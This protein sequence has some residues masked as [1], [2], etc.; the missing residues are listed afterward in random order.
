[1]PQIDIDVTH[2]TESNR[3]EAH[4]NGYTA[5]LTYHMSGDT[6][7]FTHTG[8][9]PALEGQGVGSLLAKTGLEYAKKNNLKVRTLCWFVDGYI[10]RHVEYQGLVR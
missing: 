2:H 9:P 6:I 10:Q 8:V 5:E 4:L 1:M 7:I 3:F